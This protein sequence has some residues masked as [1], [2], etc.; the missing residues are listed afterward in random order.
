MKTH[1]SRQ[2]T[3]WYLSTHTV[4]ARVQ[5]SGMA[6]FIPT[7]HMA[8]EVGLWPQESTESR[9]DAPGC[10]QLRPHKNTMRSLRWLSQPW[11]RVHKG[12]GDPVTKF[13]EDLVLSHWG[14]PVDPSPAR[15]NCV[16]RVLLYFLP[17][18][19]TSVAMA[20][21]RDAP[22]SGLSGRDI[23]HPHGPVFCRP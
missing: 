13:L 12:P 21:Y 22:W 23:G 5:D 14:N 20:S 8:E 10:L 9:R 7:A 15:D 16:H 3:G 6:G 2:Q 18:E 1:G 19:P 17:P 4:P 11:P